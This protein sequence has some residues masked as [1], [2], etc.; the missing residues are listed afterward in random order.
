MAEVLKF[1]TL[2]THASSECIQYVSER[3]KGNFS[4]TVKDTR[5]LTT[6]FLY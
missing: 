2:E 6:L 4:A 5:I 1:L 3:V